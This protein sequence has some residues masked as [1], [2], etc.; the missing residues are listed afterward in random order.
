MGHEKLPETCTSGLDGLQPK[1][2]AYLSLLCQK[3][4]MQLDSRA[5]RCD[6]FASFRVV[7]YGT[8]SSLDPR[9]PSLT[10]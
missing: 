4:E 3:A 1:F 2:G 5:G 6:G 7:S 10:R 8:E 9:L